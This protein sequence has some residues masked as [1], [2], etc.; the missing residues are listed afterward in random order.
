MNG[1]A[2]KQELREA[3]QVKLKALSETEQGRA[4]DKARELLEQQ[5]LWKNAIRI[6]FYAPVPGEIDVWPLL[7]DAL[8]A[9]KQ[10]CL[11]RF[12][13]QKAQAYAACAVRDLPRDLQTGQ[14]GIREPLA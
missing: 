7:K 12:V 8:R 6:L 13:G 1:R 9:G 5:P 14:F 4:S 2:S 3:I 11:P 10:V